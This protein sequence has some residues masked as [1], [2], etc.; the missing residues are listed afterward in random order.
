MMEMKTILWLIFGALC[1]THVF[2]TDRQAKIE[3]EEHDYIVA[4]YQEIS[5]DK[6]VDNGG[7][8]CTRIDAKQ[9]NI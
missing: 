2:L 7:I 3:R 1:L 9:E 6:F 4:K 5:E 8:I